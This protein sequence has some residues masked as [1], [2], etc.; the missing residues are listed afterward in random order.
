MHSAER[1]TIVKNKT[2][3][4]LV[5]SGKPGAVFGLT[6]D[7]TIAQSAITTGERRFGRSP[8]LNAEFFASSSH[9]ADYTP[10]I[11]L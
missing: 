2:K 5:A 6:E 1:K 10:Q 3:S 4:W 9:A 11:S 8:A 7:D